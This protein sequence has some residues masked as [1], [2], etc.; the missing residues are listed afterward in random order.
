MASDG[1]WQDIHPPHAHPHLVRVPALTQAIKRCCA[2]AIRSTDGSPSRQ[3]RDSNGEG[4]AV[5]GAPP[6]LP[7]A[8]L[9]AAA[10]AAAAGPSGMAPAGDAGARMRELGR[11]IDLGAE[12]QVCALGALLAV[13][14][15]DGLAPDHGGGPALGLRQQLDVQG[16]QQPVAWGGAPGG[17]GDDDDDEYGEEGGYYDGGFSSQGWQGRGGRGRGGRG[18][19]RRRRAVGGGDEAAAGGDA[20]LA[21][22]LRASGLV[23]VNRVSELRLSG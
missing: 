14:Q 13:M 21:A 4:D 22:A 11:H 8:A 19:G 5:E 9:D 23:F 3:L 18:G 7:A 2:L 12:Q 15:R 17:W 20:P 6:G 10:V 16:S 1:K